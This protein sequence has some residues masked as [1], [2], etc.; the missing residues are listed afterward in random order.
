MC[1]INPNAADDILA[2]CVEPLC[3]G[4]AVQHSLQNEDEALAHDNFVSAREYGKPI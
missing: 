4:V 1:W 3:R 2:A